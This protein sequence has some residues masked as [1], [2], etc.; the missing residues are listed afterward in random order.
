MPR[1]GGLRARCPQQR[2]QSFSPGRAR[3]PSARAADRAA[4]VARGVSQVSPPRIGA[5]L[6]ASRRLPPHFAQVVARPPGWIGVSGLGA[7]S[8]PA[9]S[10]T[11]FSAGL[12][13]SDRATAGQTGY[14]GTGWS[15]TGTGESI[16]RV[17][18]V[19]SAVRDRAESY[20]RPACS[21]RRIGGIERGAA[22][23][24]A[25]TPTTLS[26]AVRKVLLSFPCL[27]ALALRIRAAAAT[28]AAVASDHRRPPPARR[29]AV[30]QRSWA[31]GD[32]SFRVRT[33]SSAPAGDILQSH[34]HRLRLHRAH[35]DEVTPLD[36][37]RELAE[38]GAIGVAP[39]AYARSWAIRDPRR[40]RRR[41]T[42]PGG[43]APA[44]TAP[45]SSSS[46][47]P[48]ISCT[49]RRRRA[50]ACS[51]QAEA[52]DEGL[53]AVAIGGSGCS[54][55]TTVLAAVTVITRSSVQYSE[56]LDQPEVRSR[57]RSIC[58]RSVAAASR[59]GCSARS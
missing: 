33:L 34:E 27:E 3:R 14:Y 8:A 20:A 25:A 55:R 31:G 29:S 56:H 5:P 10:L 22:R 52:E 17:R 1:T 32:S 24:H 9:E 46:R 30:H 37:L 12:R 51:E 7:P 49:H 57:F 18:W 15:S 38:R 26:E 47:R 50:R 53:P 36:R 23:D 59:A 13:F 4:W 48:D 45:R 40:P 39:R 43:A 16:D 6:R 21:A 42:G 41:D 44:T 35:R 2:A 54:R 58:S 11:A 28:R 19:R